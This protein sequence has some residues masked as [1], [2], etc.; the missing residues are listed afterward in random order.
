MML[1]TPLSIGP[2]TLSNRIVVSPM[3]QY[4][5]NDGSMND[6]HLQHAMQMAMSGAG[7]FVVEA[8]A[9][10]RRGRITHHCVGLYSDQNEN[11][12]RRVLNAARSVATNDIKFAIQLGHAGRKASHHVPWQGGRALSKENDAW[13]TVAPSALPFTLGSPIP[14]A[15][16]RDEMQKI[17]EN[18]ISAAKR[19]IKL[20]FSAIELHGAHGYLLHEFISPISN[21][22]NDE[23]G[24]CLDNRLKF[25][26]E[27]F[28][29][30]RKIVPSDIALGLRITGTDWRDDGLSLEDAKNVAKTFEAHGADYLCISSGG[31]T[32][33]LKI[34]I[35]PNYQ[36][37]LAKGVK[38]V[39]SIPIRTVGL[40]TTAEQANDIIVN[41]EADFVALARAMLA[42]P[43]WGWDASVVLQQPIEVP[44]Q[45][46]RSYNIPK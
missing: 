18:F 33:G 35:G 32:T 30:L 11:A 24:G 39:V 13:V 41:G 28:D 42:N 12:M 40:I 6:W 37:H 7:M 43:R 25:P 19:A 5:A 23:F 1:F 16:E 9:T 17:K 26:L 20:G 44:P 8:T 4:S 22:R 36:V 10:E 46:E 31:I 3:C 27:I 34:P 21:Q 2:L 38:D 29:D 15:L 45:Y 14:E